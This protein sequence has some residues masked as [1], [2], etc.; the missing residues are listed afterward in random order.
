MYY[1]FISENSSVV[2]P[3]DQAN[4]TVSKESGEV[5]VS[6]T[7]GVWYSVSSL[8]ILVDQ[9]QCLRWLGLAG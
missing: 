6:A 1:A 4:I 2:V 3:C 9:E 8:H 7:M 5:I